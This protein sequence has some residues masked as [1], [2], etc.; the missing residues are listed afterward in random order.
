VAEVVNAD[1]NQSGGFT[2]T[3]PW[4]L[5]VCEMRFLLLSDDDVRIVF[6]ARQGLQQRH[7]G[8]AEM[9]GFRASLAIGY[10]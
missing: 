5:K 10:R 4:M 8:I 3:S 7:C 9:D 1:V 2:N 6:H